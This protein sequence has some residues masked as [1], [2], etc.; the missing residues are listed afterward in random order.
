[1]VLEGAKGLNWALDF[2]EPKQ[3]MTIITEKD[4]TSGRNGNRYYFTA[5]IDGKLVEFLVGSDSY[6]KYGEGAGIT[7]NVHKGAL[8]MTYY[9]LKE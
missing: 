1:M 5:Y 4:H 9:T 3:V 2:S 8:G 6:D 7:V